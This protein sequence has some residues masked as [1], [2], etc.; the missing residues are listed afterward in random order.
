MFTRQMFGYTCR[1]LLD[2]LEGLFHDNEANVLQTDIVCILYYLCLFVDLSIEHL[3]NLV[4][5]S[6]NVLEHTVIDISC[7]SSW[8]PTE[9]L[10]WKSRHR[11]SLSGHLAK[12]PPH[13]CPFTLSKAHWTG[14]HRGRYFSDATYWTWAHWCAFTPLSCDA[15]RF[16][17]LCVTNLL[18]VR[19]LIWPS[20]TSGT[21]C[22]WAGSINWTRCDFGGPLWGDCARARQV[23]HDVVIGFGV[24]LAVGVVLLFLRLSYFKLYGRAWLF[25]ALYFFRRRLLITTPH[26]GPPFTLR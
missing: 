14:S 23:K 12:S 6:G 26:S 24:V 19:R 13:R 15:S 25:L 11:A 3:F 10:P 7:I 8:Y 17:F 4:D 2:P 21:C 5:V 22:R 1:L 9:A 18:T 20:W 16:C